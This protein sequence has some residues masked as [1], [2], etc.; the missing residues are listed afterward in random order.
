MEREDLAFP[1][2]EGSGEAS[3]EKAFLTGLKA[4]R[5]G[6]IQHYKEISANLDS[7]AEIYFIVIESRLV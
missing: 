2:S 5:G 4:P 1:R 7:S 6:W 3:P